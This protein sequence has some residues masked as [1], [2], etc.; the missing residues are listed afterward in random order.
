MITEKHIKEAGHFHKMIEDCITEI[1]YFKM[2]GELAPI[3]DL[4]DEFEV[5]YAGMKLVGISIETRQAY[6]DWYKDIML[7]DGG[8]T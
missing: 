7:W 3:E 6:R 4:C 5:H 2:V 1:A 8:K